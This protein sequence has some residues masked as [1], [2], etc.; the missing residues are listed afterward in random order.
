[1]TILLKNAK[2]YDGT[3][4]PPFQGDLLLKDDRIAR[5]AP[6]IDAAADKIYDLQGKSVAPGFIDSHSHNDWF[7]I[8]PN[9]LPCFEPFIRQGITSFVTGN[10]GLSAIGFE[11]ETPYTDQIGGGLF[12]YRGQT[13]GVYPDAQS[14]FEAVDGNMPCN[15]AVLAGHCSARAS[16][17]GGENRKLTPEE[18]QQMLAILEENLKQGAAGISLGLMY[19][20]GLYADEEE[21]K[22]VAAL[23]VKYDRPLTVHPP[24]GV[25][26]LDGLSP[27][28]GP[29][30]S[31]EG[32]GRAGAHC[33]RHESQAAVFPFYFRRSQHLFR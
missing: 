31:A 8:R 1:M 13:T 2:I 9:C 28:A 21:L 14:L 22:K 3:A 32:A 25:Q 24:G 29:F 12:G 6:R 30:S 10:C 17:A 27:A 11:K 18:E 33:Q 19:S 4:A 23:C 20:P 16:V 26:G 15:I 5:V 7:A